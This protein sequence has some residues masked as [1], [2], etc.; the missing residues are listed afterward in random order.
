MTEIEVKLKKGSSLDRALRL[1]KKKLDREGILKQVKSHRYYE[2]PS[3]RR[4]R[5]IKIAQF[6]NMLIT[7]YYEDLT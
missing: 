4:R 6:N 2:K 1:L 5:R 7:K 3:E